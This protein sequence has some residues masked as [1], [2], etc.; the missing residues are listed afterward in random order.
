MIRRAPNAAAISWV[1]AALAGDSRTCNAIAAEE[2]IT[3]VAAAERQFPMTISIP[4]P[5]TDDR[6][7]ACGEAYTA[8]QHPCKPAGVSIMIVCKC[9]VVTDTIDGV[10]VTY[11]VPPERTDL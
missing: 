10:S 3:A 9:E 4:L 1:A 8:I 5:T 7:F 11:L 2:A 6:C